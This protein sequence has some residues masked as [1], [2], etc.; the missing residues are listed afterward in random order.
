MN[1]PL[2]A[3]LVS[4][5]L[6][7]TLLSSPD[8]IAQS[9]QGRPVRLIVP[10]GPAGLT[11]AMGR[12]L[13]PSFARALGQPVIVENKPGASGIV[14]FEYVAKQVP[15]DGLTLLLG[16][17]ALILVHLFTKDLRFDPVKDLPPVSVLLD[18]VLMMEASIA[19]PFNTFSEMLAYAKANPG[20]INGGAIGA[21]GL[22]ALY[23]E[24]I[25][26]VQGIDLVT[27]AYKSGPDVY[28]ALYSNQVQLAVVNEAQ[29]RNDFKSGRAKILAVSHD[30]RLA[31]FPNVPTL[32]EVGHPDITNF[33]L[34][35][36]VTAG[37]PS[38]TVSRLHAAVRAAMQEAEFREF[39]AKG[40]M[41]IVAAPPD[42]SEK[43]LASEAKFYATVAQKAGIKPQ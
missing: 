30:K 23:W 8:G 22:Q 3:T 2:A 36:N 41:R 33:W 27:V 29:A 37:T 24:A 38:A 34:S 15:P 9:S 19:S 26:Q 6:A 13:A 32:A 20:K 1:R 28:A 14:A 7:F 18:G 4:V 10:T 11:D 35:M 25:K 40:L 31:E 5:V 16:N 39:A 43:M 21:Q 17:Q 42:V 12:V